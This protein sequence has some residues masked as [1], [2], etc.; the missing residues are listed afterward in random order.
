MTFVTVKPK[1]ILKFPSLNIFSGNNLVVCFRNDNISHSRSYN[2]FRFTFHVL[3]KTKLRY[4]TAHYFEFC[5]THCSNVKENRNI[6]IFHFVELGLFL[7][8]MFLIAKHSR[9]NPP[10]PTKNS[11]IPLK[12]NSSQYLTTWHVCL[13]SVIS[14][15][16]WTG[17]GETQS[18]SS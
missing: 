13:P 8:S 10:P 16:F 15:L 17:S 14:V 18:P 6:N 5:F 7:E 3:K 9:Y 12:Q 11:C 2:N 4:F 1:E